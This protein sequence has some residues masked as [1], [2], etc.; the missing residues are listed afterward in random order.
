MYIV[1]FILGFDDNLIDVNIMESI[2]GEYLLNKLL[3]IKIFFY[4]G[5]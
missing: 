1:W 4:Y 3:F 5:Y 2:Y